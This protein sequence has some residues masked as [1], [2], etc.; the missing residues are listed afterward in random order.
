MGF[1]KKTAATATT[2]A[3]QPVKSHEINFTKYMFW[4]AAVVSLSGFVTGWHIG[5][6]SK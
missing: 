3:N 1:F 5:N 4:C 2:S 6:V